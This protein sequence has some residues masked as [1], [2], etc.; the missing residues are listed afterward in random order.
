MPRG[1]KKV[2]EHKHHGKKKQA[3]GSKRAKVWCYGCDHELVLPLV[4]KKRARRL[5]KK[6]TKEAR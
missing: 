5:V 3:Y 6:E 2:C 4:S 1:K